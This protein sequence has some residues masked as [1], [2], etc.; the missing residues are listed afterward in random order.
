M[1]DRVLRET[2]VTAFPSR[3]WIR[4]EKMSLRRSG[5]FFILWR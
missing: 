3:T 5:I 1:F 4:A 2:A